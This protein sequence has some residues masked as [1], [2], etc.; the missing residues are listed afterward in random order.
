MPCGSAA[1]PDANVG[2]QG[3]RRWQALAWG[4]AAGGAGIVLATALAGRRRRHRESPTAALAAVRAL[5]DRAASR[6]DVA[7]DVMD[8]LLFA[9][10]RRWVAGQAQ[11]TV[12]EVA[13][14]T[15]R[16]LAFY[17]PGIR[18]TLLDISP[19]M[20]AVAGKRA[21]ALGRDVH[22]EV[23]DAQALAGGDGGVDTVVCTL[24]L[25]SVPDE[26]R[27][28]AEAWRVLRPGGRLL[29]LEHVKSPDPV[30]Q[31]VQRL[32]APCACAL[33]CD[34]LLRDPLPVVRDA[35]FE[36]EQVERH[37]LGIV[38]WLAARKPPEAPTD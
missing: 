12:L 32:M 33:F 17:P 13:A 18:L 28:V 35:G 9:D 8:H 24:G 27:A 7:M 5:Y 20:M 38:Q 6:Y 11:G 21:A 37:A 19:R 31:Q 34:H 14:G 36:V 29:L 1:F 3:G 23:G 15:G 30:V 22:L 2:Y 16:N 25:C 26:R 4:V 10:G